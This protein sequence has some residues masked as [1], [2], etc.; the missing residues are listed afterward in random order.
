M[1]AVGQLLGCVT[2]AVAVTASLA[3]GAAVACAA[4]CA[5]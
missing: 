2:P 4:W 3:T 5:N 1:D